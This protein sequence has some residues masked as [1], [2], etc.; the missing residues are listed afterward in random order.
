MHPSHLMM[1]KLPILLLLIFLLIR[2]F[3]N[4]R[5]LNGIGTVKRIGTTLLFIALIGFA[6]CANTDP[7]ATAS[8]AVFALNA[9]HWQPSPAD[10]TIP[11][12]ASNQ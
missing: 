9:G 3:R 6:G 2:H 10:L 12:A 8:G 5:A 11:P 7:L 4:G 1:M